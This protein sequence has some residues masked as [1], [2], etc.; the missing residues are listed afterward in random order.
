MNKAATKPR[1]DITKNSFN[2][3]RLG[4]DTFGC[5]VV[6]SNI[7]R[8]AKDNKIDTR[9]NKSTLA[10]SLKFSKNIS[11]LLMLYL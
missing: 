6:D 8:R 11:N 3:M 2:E 9:I 5:S 4:F 7:G 10:G 1:G